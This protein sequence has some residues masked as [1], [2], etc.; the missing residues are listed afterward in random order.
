MPPHVASPAV[1]QDAVCPS[2]NPDPANL[3]GALIS[4]RPNTQPDRWQLFVYN[5]SNS[6]ITVA[7]QTIA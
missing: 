5:P 2:G 3:P 4:W 6:G 1:H 7:A